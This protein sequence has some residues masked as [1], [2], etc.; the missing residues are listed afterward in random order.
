MKSQLILYS[1]LMIDD[2]RHK[3]AYRFMP[4]D[5][6][7]MLYPELADVRARNLLTGQQIME[8]EQYIVCVRC[9]RQCAGTC[10]P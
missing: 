2:D 1:N 3:P 4:G 8:L 9:G 6:V 5:Y 7:A 10:R